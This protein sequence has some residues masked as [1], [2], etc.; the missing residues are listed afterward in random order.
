MD[1]VMRIF[2]F[3]VSG[4]SPFLFPGRKFSGVPLGLGI[5]VET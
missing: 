1:F 5:Y 2:I 3:S 4:S